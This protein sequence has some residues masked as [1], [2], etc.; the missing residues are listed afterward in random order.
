MKSV[1]SYDAKT[2]LARHLEEVARGET[3]VITKH[4]V[5]VAKLVPPGP[6]SVNAEQAIRELQSLREWVQ[7]LGD[8]TIRDVIEEGRRF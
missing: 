3:S 2:N 7:P 8:L 6:S 1:G 5:P 4:G